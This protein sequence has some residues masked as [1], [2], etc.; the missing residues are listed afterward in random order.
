MSRGRHFAGGVRGGPDMCGVVAL[1]GAR[2]AGGGPGRPGREGAPYGLKTD[3]RSAVREP[4]GASSAGG[5]RRCLNNVSRL[6][7]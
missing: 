2:V 5:P 1:T 4:D 7:T 6:G 3:P